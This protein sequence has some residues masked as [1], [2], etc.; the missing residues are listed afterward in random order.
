VRA[1]TASFAGYVLAGAIQFLERECAARGNRSVL[2]GSLMRIVRYPRVGKPSSVDAHNLDELLMLLQAAVSLTNVD[3]WL[4]QRTIE[5][6]IET[7]NMAAS[8]V[9][10]RV[11]DAAKREQYEVSVVDEFV[12]LGAQSFAMRGSEVVW[13]RPFH[14]GRPGAPPA[15]DV[16][17]FHA[18]RDEE[19]RI[20]FGFYSRPKLQ[21]DAQKLLALSPNRST[22]VVTAYLALWEVVDGAHRAADTDRWR[23]R[24]VDDANWV[25]A[26]INGSVVL[27]V[28]S[29]QDLF[30]AE[31]GRHRFVR[32]A[33]FSV[34]EDTDGN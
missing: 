33:I 32:A 3:R 2:E 9:P 7:K 5:L 18:G 20:E 22:K 11:R 14:T 25:T 24:C 12:R 34:H 19:S 17:L 31:P 29:T 1:L 27:R 13:E 6:A 15:V 8:I 28:A 16:S 26:R 21:R 23:T 10:T 30:V 4:Q